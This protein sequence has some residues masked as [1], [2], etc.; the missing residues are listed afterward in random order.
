MLL[1][2]IFCTSNIIKSLFINV[3]G[4][5]LYFTR[6]GIYLQ[7][8]DIFDNIWDIMIPKRLG[9][10]LTNNVDVS[11]FSICQGNFFFTFFV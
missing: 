7:Y 3:S 10:R 8:L 5:S 4:L 9:V 11:A 2:C 6:S 1:Y